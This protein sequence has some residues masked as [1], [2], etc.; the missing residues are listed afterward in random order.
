MLKINV[1]AAATACALFAAGGALAQTSS[2][3]SAAAP[4]FSALDKNNDGQISRS[5]WNEHSRAGAAS[6]A[7]SDVTGGK[8]RGPTERTG[9]PEVGGSKSGN[10]GAAS[11]G[12]SGSTAA[13]SSGASAG[14]SASG[15]ADK[16]DAGS[17]RGYPTAPTGEPRVGGSSSK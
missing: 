8:K 13:G 12:S 10:E 9:K 17:Q 5:E 1:L 14:A 2:S 6:G 4:S 3:S 16:A 15:R 11:G 7:S